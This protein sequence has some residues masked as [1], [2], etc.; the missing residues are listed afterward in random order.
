M[1]MTRPFLW[2]LGVLCLAIPL[3][4]AGRPAGEELLWPPAPDIPRIRYMTALPAPVSTPAAPASFPQKTVRWLLGLPN[5]GARQETVLLRPTALW[6]SGDMVYVA[7]PG[8]RAIVTYHL[9]TK[10]FSRLPVPRGHPLVSPV[11][12]VVDGTGRLFISDSAAR[13]VLIMSSDGR[14]LGRLQPRDVPWLRPTGLTFDVVTA[15]VYVA[16]TGRHRICVFDTTNRHLFSFGDRGSG[17]GQFNLPTYLWMDAKRRTLAVTDSGNFRI[18]LFDGDG[19]WQTS[20]GHTGNRPGYL[21]RPHG[22][23]I[24]SEGHIYSVD[25]AMETVQ[26]FNREGRLLLYVG[27]GG[28]QAGF[29]ALPGGLFIDSQDRIYVADTYNARIQIFQY[30]RAES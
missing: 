7:D 3:V 8:L 4:V 24:D 9:S 29:F 14:L 30:L 11:A 28:I 26:I 15:R 13:Q 18:Q 10:R 23:A 1:S 19:R 12:L 25:G 17:P 22:V 5:R 21:A 2:A 20:L 6:V 16:D 27:E